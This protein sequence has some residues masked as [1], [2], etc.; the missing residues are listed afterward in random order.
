MRADPTPAERRLWNALRNRQLGAR[1][2]RQAPL[3][4][5]IVDFVCFERKLV[6]EAD[7][8]Q[9]ADSPHDERRDAWL[10]GQG[11]RVLRFWNVDILSNTEGV[12]TAIVEA[13]AA[14]HPDPPPQG[15]R[16]TS[17]SAAP[18]SSVARRCCNSAASCCLAHISA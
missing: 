8:G 12:L 10:A 17:H 6:V 4:P 18:S 16:E 13:L 15:G 3:G 14:P 2:R 7:G 5:Y 1:F 11:F 9:H